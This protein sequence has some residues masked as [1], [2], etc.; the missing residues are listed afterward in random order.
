MERSSLLIIEAM[1]ME[2][3][4]V[5]PRDAT[6]KSINVSINDRVESSKILVEFE[7]LKI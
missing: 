3:L 2:N 4:I 7:N 5:S 1:K 6:V